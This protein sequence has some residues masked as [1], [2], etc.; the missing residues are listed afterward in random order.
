MNQISRIKRLQRDLGVD[1]D[2]VIGS[3]TLTAIEKQIYKSLPD[4]TDGEI[5]GI[6]DRSAKN[7]LT[8]IHR[9]REPFEKFLR[10]AKATAATMGCDYVAI[11]GNRTWDEQKALYAQ[12]RTAPGKKVTN[13][14]P[15]SSWHNFGIAL[16]F[17]VFRDGAYLDSSDAELAR[18]VHVACSKH[19]KACGLEWGGSW[20]T[21]KDIPHYQMNVNMGLAQAREL[22]GKGQWA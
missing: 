19:A 8:L 14:K 9:A 3:R 4:N 11:S 21:F 6:D 2:G 1:D 13:A 7:I 5:D 15:G 22:Y 10:L 20:R 18:R 17:G 12:G 16:D